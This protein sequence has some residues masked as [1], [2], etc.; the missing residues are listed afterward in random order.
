MKKFMVIVLALAL[1]LSFSG[2]TQSDSAQMVK[3]DYEAYNWEGSD[4]MAK[5]TEANSLVMRI[6][7]LTASEQQELTEIKGELEKMI[8]EMDGKD[9]VIESPNPSMMPDG[10]TRGDTAYPQNTMMPNS[11]IY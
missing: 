7:K 10:S 1:V 6:E 3:N 8:A 11:P 9:D 2:C 4:D 5:K